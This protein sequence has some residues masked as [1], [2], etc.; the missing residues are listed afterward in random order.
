MLL[1]K[2]G[3]HLQPRLGVSSLPGGYFCVL[4]CSNNLEDLMPKSSMHFLRILTV[5]Q[6]LL[7]RLFVYT[8][9]IFNQNQIKFLMC[10]I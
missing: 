9:G 2:W 5:P 3:L 10:V 6:I 8:V 7:I 4:V 1:M